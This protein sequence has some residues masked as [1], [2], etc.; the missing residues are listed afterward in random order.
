MGKNEE[1]KG[2]NWGWMQIIT[3]IVEGIT[4]IPAATAQSNNFRNMISIGLLHAKKT[5]NNVNC[6]S[7][8]KMGC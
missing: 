3:A 8:V 4:I 2:G 1:R 6:N 5:K 7:A